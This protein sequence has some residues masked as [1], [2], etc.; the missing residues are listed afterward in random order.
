MSGVLFARVTA[1]PSPRFWPCAAFWFQLPP[2]TAKDAEEYPPHILL[3]DL[4]PMSPPRP[5]YFLSLL[6]LRLFRNLQGSRKKETSVRFSL[7]GLR[8]R[9]AR[10]LSCVPFADAP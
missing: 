6:P 2:L 5:S 1:M 8:N 3:T 7:A 4:S 10:P 9:L